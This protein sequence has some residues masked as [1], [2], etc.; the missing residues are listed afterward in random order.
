M[1]GVT[2]EEAVENKEMRF[3]TLTYCHYLL[4]KTSL[5]LL[6]AQKMFTRIITETNSNFKN[7]L[8]E[9]I[10]YAATTETAEFLNARLAA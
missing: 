4:T 1:F 6:K 9:L 8:I 10:Q 5:Y 7:S 2:T 3:P